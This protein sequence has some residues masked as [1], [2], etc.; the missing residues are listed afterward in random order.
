MKKVIYTIVSIAILAVLVLWLFSN[1]K[2]AESKVYHYNKQ[3]AVLVSTDTSILRELANDI[4]FTGTFEALREGKVMSESQGMLIRMD[5]ELGKNMHKGDIV[6]QL[7]N[8]L[9]KLQLEAIE[10]Q[11]KGYEKD[12][13]RYTV[14][15]EANAVQGIQLEKTS[16]ALEGAKIQRKTMQE[17]IERTTIRA[18]FSGVVTQK[19][20][21]L[22]TFISPPVPLIQMTDISQVKMTLSVPES[23]LK[24]FR[25]NQKLDVS[26]DIYPDRQFSGKIVMVGSK[27]DFAHNYP[28]QIQVVNTPDHLIKAGM[29]GSVTITKQADQT[30]PSIPVKALIGS[31]IHPQ[32][33]VVEEGK[34]VLRDLTVAYQNEKYAAISSGLSVGEVVVASGFINLKNGSPLRSR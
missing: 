34:A 30:Y 26:V 9:L 22:G 20:T 16:L 8:E 3:E 4:S 2:T 15:A 25:L 27:G 6:A 32:V 14:L 10:V 29:F 23:D 13:D 7:D 1:K 19:F 31:T 5:A 11:I 21:E 17:Q 18:P 28:V 33:Y 24:L 12:L